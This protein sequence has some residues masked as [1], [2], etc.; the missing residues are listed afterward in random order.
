[1]DIAES[2]AS[3]GAVPWRHLGPAQ[4][5][6]N[7]ALTSL[8]QADT[9]R[10][11]WGRDGTLWKEAR[12]VVVAIENRLGWLD[13]PALAPLEVGRLRAVSAE[14]EAFGYDELVLL[15][16]GGS[17][18]AAETL[19]RVIRP[20]GGPMRFTILDT[21][22]PAQIR[23]VAEGYDLSRT[24][25][26]VSSKSGTTPETLSLYAYFRHLCRET[27]GEAE[28]PKHFM[29]ITD[30]Q[31]PLEES[32][33]TDALRGV[34][35]GPPDVGGRF[36]ALSL[37]G[38]L[39]AA[40]IG[41]DLDA[42]LG[43]AREMAR[44]CRVTL[45]EGEN[46]AIVLGAAMGALA[47]RDDGRRD[48][49]TLITSPRLH[50]IGPWVEQLIAEST[51]KEGKG[52]VP[53]VGERLDDPGRFGRDR[54]WVYMRLDG[55]DNAACDAFA[56]ALVERDEPIV[57]LRL[58]DEYDLGAE[59]F[60][61]EFATAV[62]GCLLGVNPFDQ[63]NVEA[64]KRQAAQALVR[65]EETQRLPQDP[66]VT[67]EGDLRVYGPPTGAEGVCDYL[68]AFWQ[69]ARPGDYGALLAFVERNESHH[70]V[71][72][73]VAHELETWLGIP[74]TVGFGPRYLH[75]TGQLHKGGPNSVL[76]LQITADNAVDADIPEHGYSFAVLKRAQALG[77]LAALQE[78]GRRA[79]RVH[80][81]ADPLAGLTALLQA[82]RVAREAC[83]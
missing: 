32:A 59:F 52:I 71:L 7:D 34:F 28:W 24:L 13:L 5:V 75:S 41:V 80:V 44:A 1:M 9:T 47:A 66:P 79:V 23:R 83:R 2:L 22:D 56:G 61:W 73:E 11:I 10:R 30:T 51:G 21:T 14:V 16:M 6:V 69:Q 81:G 65:Y 42:L 12:A 45:A 82:V 48:K 29:A 60:R 20:G 46:P 39:P 50:P 74:V 58:R 43:R 68:A 17:S 36:S 63:P 64:A 19:S 67:E 37:Y 33:T 8:R 15:G 25:F 18:L 31:T 76:A 35:Q 40:L 26:L 53:V 72:V 3:I 77:D 4:G 62:A 27:L 57:A 78:A 55:D 38:L 54:L 70:N 49:L